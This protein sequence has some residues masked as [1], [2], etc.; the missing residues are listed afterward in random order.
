VSIFDD[1]ACMVPI[2]ST[3][4]E[5]KLQTHK[6]VFHVASVSRNYNRQ[7]ENHY[8]VSDVLQILIRF[9]P[10]NNNLKLFTLRF[11]SQTMSCMLTLA[12]SSLVSKVSTLSSL[13][14]WRLKSLF[15]M[16]NNLMGMFYSCF[17]Y[18]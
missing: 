2:Q 15:F 13:C 18:G 8:I 4:E 7:I 17:I 12:D 6:H 11:W 10:Q 3:A 14:V 1:F 5:D 9:S 16:C